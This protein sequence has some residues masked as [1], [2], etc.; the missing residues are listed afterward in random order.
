MNINMDNNTA[1][2]IITIYIFANYDM[3]VL[4]RYLN[5]NN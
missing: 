3:D 2:E 5:I 1:K 4:N